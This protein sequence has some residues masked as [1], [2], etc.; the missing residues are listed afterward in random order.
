M[1]RKIVSYL[2]E[3]KEENNF[4]KILDREDKKYEKGII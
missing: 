4:N 1:S 3:R 2:N